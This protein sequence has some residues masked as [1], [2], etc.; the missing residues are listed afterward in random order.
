MSP[1]HIEKIV[2]AYVL[3]LEEIGVIA[4]RMETDRT[5]KSLSNVEILQHSKHLCINILTFLY[6][7]YNLKSNDEHYNDLKEKTNRHLAALQV[8]LSFAGLYTHW[9]NSWLI[10]ENTHIKWQKDDMHISLDYDGTYTEDPVLWDSF[11]KLAVVR[12]HKVTC[13]TM[14]HGRDEKIEIGC[15]IIYT[16][17][18]AKLEAVAIRGIKI[19]VWIDDSPHW[20]F[21]DAR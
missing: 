1:E 16:D 11:I 2:D 18:L 17:R 5:F 19:D 9:M 10:I 7:L 15:P 14:R 8:C 20:I 13:V 21:S 4:L 6:K 12:G 3:R